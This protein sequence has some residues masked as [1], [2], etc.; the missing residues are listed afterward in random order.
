MREKEENDKEEE[1]RKENS[2][3]GIPNFSSMIMLF[4]LCICVCYVV[5][6]GKQSKRESGT[7]A[8]LSYWFI[9]VMK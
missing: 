8:Q 2:I 5:V 6:G 9:A 4:S 7:C 1:K 3:S